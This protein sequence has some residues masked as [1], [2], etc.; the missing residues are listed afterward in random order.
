MERVVMTV[1]TWVVARVIQVSGRSWRLIEIER[2][3]VERG[4]RDGGVIYAF[5]HG[6]MMVPAYTH[7]RRGIHVLI[8]EHRDGEYID[9]VIRRLGF[10]SV[11]GSTTR[12][13]AKALFGMA[14]AGHRGHDL[15]V[16]PDGP[17]GP[18]F[19]FQT[20]VLSIAQRTGLAVI[21]AGVAAHPCLVL[22]SWD[23]FVIPLPFCR[24][25]IVYGE[26]VIVPRDCTREA[27][28]RLRI[29]AESTLRGLT[30]RAERLSRSRAGRRLRAAL[31]PGGQPGDG[32]EAAS[33]TPTRETRAH[34]ATPG[35]NDGS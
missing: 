16:T 33:P 7:R 11:R 25:V 14:G 20:G 26:P 28:E 27:L 2:D 22:R 12:G 6:R 32:V 30:A 29:E 1:A 8:S 17:G 4:R 18:R 9:R 13:G 19:R 23:R 15:A 3:Q 31:G 24:C 5:W 35:G 10:G 21:P 34:G